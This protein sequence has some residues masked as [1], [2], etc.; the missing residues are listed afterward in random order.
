MGYYWGIAEALE[1]LAALAAARGE[2]ERA[3]RLAGAAAVVRAERVI[4]PSSA[5][6]AD[7]IRQVEAAGRALPDETA[8]AAYAAGRELPLERVVA[9]ALD[10]ADEMATPSSALTV[11]HPT[12]NQT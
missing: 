1:G 6:Q 8:A 4:P 9:E 5:S 2:V 7:L 12:V 11:N 3:L 10:L